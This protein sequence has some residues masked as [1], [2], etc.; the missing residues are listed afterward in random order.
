MNADKLSK[1]TRIANSAIKQE[2]NLRG[3]G[4]FTP[5]LLQS[6]VNLMLRSIKCGRRPRPG[7]SY[8]ID[9]G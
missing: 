8:F 6:T 2:E 7:G 4:L 5:E 3:E 9:L 1:I